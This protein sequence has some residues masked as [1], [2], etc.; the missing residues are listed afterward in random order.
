MQKIIKKMWVLIFPLIFSQGCS[1]PVISPPD[2]PI[3]ELLS[4]PTELTINGK[5]VTLNTSIWEN[6]MP[7]I[8]PSPSHLTVI[9]YIMAKDSSALPST[10][11]L[12]SVY[13]IYFNQVWKSFL[14]KDNNLTTKNKFVGI[15]YDGP[16]WKPGSFADVIVKISFN[17]SYYL[18]R[19]PHQLIGAV[20]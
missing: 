5:V 11:E 9:C 13:M 12:N 15:A 18:I 8:P 2:I 7:T 20:Y 3:N 14:E 19:A 1:N 17:G 4:A 16:A 6:F 10:M